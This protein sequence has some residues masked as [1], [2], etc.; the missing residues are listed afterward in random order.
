MEGKETAQP[1]NANGSQ[2]SS[3]SLCCAVTNLHSEMVSDLELLGTKGRPKPKL[4]LGYSP[5]VQQTH[6]KGCDPTVT[7]YGVK[8][9]TAG[10]QRFWR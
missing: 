2:E 5:S 10:E 9:T 7:S 6:L 4:G 3:E 1:R 8:E